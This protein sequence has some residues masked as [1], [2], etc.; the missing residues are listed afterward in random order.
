MKQIADSDTEAV[1]K[2]LDGKSALAS[3]APPQPNQAISYT[4]YDERSAS[5][6]FESEKEF[7]ESLALPQDDKIGT[8]FFNDP[9]NP[10][11]GSYENARLSKSLPLL[12]QDES[13]TKFA[14]ELDDSMISDDE[15][16]DSQFR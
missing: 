10:R 13:L 16:D 5:I 6:N 2:L 4:V 12:L 3:E 9:A 15:G 14:R 11:S 7:K 8:G 1:Q